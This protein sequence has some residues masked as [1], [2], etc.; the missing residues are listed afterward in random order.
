MI[1][2]VSVELMKLGTI[3]MVNI[4][5]VNVLNGVSSREATYFSIS[6]SFNRGWVRRQ[7]QGKMY[8]DNFITCFK[9]D[10]DEIFERIKRDKG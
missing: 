1:P 8:G 10:I 7:N 3:I 6:H 9:D 5:E 2:P 4:S